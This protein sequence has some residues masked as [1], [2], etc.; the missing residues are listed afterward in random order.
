MRKRFRRPVLAAAVLAVVAAVATGSPAQAVTSIDHIANDT[1]WTDTSGN[2]IKAQ[3]GNIQK[4]G[5]VWYWVGS[6][7]TA[8]Q[9]KSIN[10]YSSPDLENWTFVKALV[11]QWSGIGT[12]TVPGDNATTDPAGDDFITGA[13]LGRPQ[14]VYNAHSGLW[15]LWAEVNSHTEAKGNAQAIFTSSSDLI[16]S[17]YTLV[18]QPNDPALNNE[19]YL[20][21]DSAGELVTSGD[22]SLFVEGNNAYLVYVGDSTTARDKSINIAQ[23]DADWTHIANTALIYTLPYGGQE[24]PGVIKIGGDYYLFASGQNGWE[25]TPTVYRTSKTLSGFLNT[26]GTWNAV[27]EAPS[28]SSGKNSFATQFEQIIPV[29]DSTGTVQYLYNGDRY[30]E[31]AG[32]NDYPLEGVGRNAFYPLTFTNGVPTLH[33][34]TD[35]KVNTAGGTLYWNWITNGR[36]DQTGANSGTVPYWGS[37]GTAGATKVEKQTGSDGQELVQ[38]GTNFS[39]YASQGV[40][41]PNGNYTLQLQY[42]LAGTIGHAYV[43]IKGNNASS[44]TTETKTSFTA[45]GSGYSSLSV[46]FTVSSG[47]T[48]IGTWVDT[49]GTATLETDDFA[50][51]SR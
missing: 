41:L 10:L 2:P 18:S 40:T 42:K 34:A 21:K 19:D 4:V 50:I 51:W 36:F 33:G 37:T 38:A 20:V 3:G 9:P 26:A 22:R 44:P 23:L 27:P 32:T 15:V 24:A 16:D 47:K 46:D 39:S 13:W 29:T 14:L 7:F 48:T 1:A 11:T 25:P 31:F 6:A 43:G 30:S 12:D 45:G 8:G 28:A 35:V 17:N 49:P 5:S